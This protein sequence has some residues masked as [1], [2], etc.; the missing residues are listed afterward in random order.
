MIRYGVEY[1]YPYDF[2]WAQWPL[3]LVLALEL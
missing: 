3:I 2:K 1:G